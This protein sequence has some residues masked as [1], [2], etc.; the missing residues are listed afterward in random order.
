[1]QPAFV[2]RTGATFRCSPRLLHDIQ[3][4]QF[5][6][7]GCSNCACEADAMRQ[8][9]S[10]T[11]SHRDVG[12]CTSILTPLK[13]P[14]N[15]EKAQLLALLC[16]VSVER[17]QAGDRRTRGARPRSDGR[18]RRGR[19]SSA[20]RLVLIAESSMKSKIRINDDNNFRMYNVRRVVFNTSLLGRW[21]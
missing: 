12:Y 15:P 10:L 17:D 6:F 16:Y 8:R 18:S 4:T 13:I 3:T 20:R 7:I 1:M 9:A 21:C 11:L 14:L 19:N 5:A 2:A